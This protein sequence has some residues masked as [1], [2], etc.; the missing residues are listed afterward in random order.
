[1]PRSDVEAG[2][3]GLLDLAAADPNNVPV[4]LAMATGFL[5]LGQTPKARNQL[6]RVQKLQVRRGGRLVGQ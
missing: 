6:K 2:L 1:M 3:S 5:M 4:L